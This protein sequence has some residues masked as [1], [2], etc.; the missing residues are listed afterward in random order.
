M[1]Q[2]LALFGHPV[3]HSKS[4]A[5]HGVFGKENGIDLEYDLWDVPPET[6]VE[7]VRHAFE[8][9]KIVGANVTVP[10]KEGVIK[11]CDH[12]TSEAK[13]AGAV[14]TLHFRDGKLWGHNTDGIGLVRDLKAKGA[15]LSGKRILILGA[16]GATRGALKPILDELPESVVLVNRTVSRAEQLMNEYYAHDAAY[17]RVLTATSWQDEMLGERVFDVIINATSSSLSKMFTPLPKGAIG[18][19]TIGYDLMYSDEPT[20]FMEYLLEKG[21]K[22]A[23]D[24]IGMLIEQA[25]YA[26]QFW[27]NCLPD[28]TGVYQLLRN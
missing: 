3:S 17:Q 2:M 6:L 4:P 19:D 11:A 27:F 22:A 16:G 18:G 7:T 8:T 28:T 24:G 1:T 14:N 21:G 13:L 5:I 23:F 10:H 20:V 9:G 15:I 25:A 12:L 26:F